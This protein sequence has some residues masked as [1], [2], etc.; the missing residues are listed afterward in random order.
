MFYSYM[1]LNKCLTMYQKAGEGECKLEQCETHVDET[2]ARH[3]ERRNKEIMGLKR[4]IASLLFHCCLRAMVLPHLCRIISV[5]R[6]I[7]TLCW[8]SFRF[9]LQQKGGRRSSCGTCFMLHVKTENAPAS[10][11]A[12]DYSKSFQTE[13]DCFKFSALYSTQEF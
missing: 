8:W 3:V 10:Q 6:I 9:R 2:T 4:E 12:K 1:N 11:G 5:R 7:K 13:L